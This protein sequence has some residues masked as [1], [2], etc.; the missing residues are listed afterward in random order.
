MAGLV[1]A[2]TVRIYCSVAVETAYLPHGNLISCSVVVL[3]WLPCVAGVFS[4]LIVFSYS[5]EGEIKE[6]V[7]VS[8]THG[9]A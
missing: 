1:A 7:H 9:Q 5:S 6:K 2:V 3:N 8:R 4:L